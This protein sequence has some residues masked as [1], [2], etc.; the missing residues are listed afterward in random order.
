MMLKIEKKSTM[1]Y[2]TYY[3][4]TNHRFSWS[5]V[6]GQIEGHIEGEANEQEVGSWVTSQYLSLF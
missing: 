3:H 1:F 5:W 4:R 2:N 6:G